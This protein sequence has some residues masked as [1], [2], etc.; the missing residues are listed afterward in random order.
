MKKF[1]SL[2]LAVLMIV[3]LTVSASA[4]SILNREGTGLIKTNNKKFA[5]DDLRDIYELLDLPYGG[6]FIFRGETI[7]TWWYDDCPVC[8]GLSF[9]FVK[10]GDIIW[11]CLEPKCGKDGVISGDDGKDDD[12]YVDDNIFCGENCPSCGTDRTKFDKVVVSG[13]KLY[14]RYYCFYCGKY[15]YTEYEDLDDNDS[16]VYDDIRCWECGK[17]AEF[18][19]FFVSGGKLYARYTCKDGHSTD[20]R[21]YGSINYTE[22]EYNVRVICTRGGDY[23]ISGGNEAYYGETKTIEF[24][25]L[26]GYVLT[27]VLVNGE[28]VEF[29]SSNKIQITVTKNTVVRAYFEK[30]S[31]LKSYTI[32]AEA[33]GNGRI[34]A[35][36]N[37]EYVTADKVTAKYTDTV[38]YRFIPASKNYYIDSV[39]VDGRY[40][41]KP[42]S[43]TFTKLNAN[44][45][46]EVNF[47]WDNPFCD[48]KD[49]YLDAV[50]YVTEAGI[51]SASKTTG[52]KTYFSGN[53]KVSVQSFA[54][55]LAEMADTSD[56]LDNTDERVL[57]A[58]K[59]DL[60]DEDTDLSATCDVQTACAMVREF[61]E[62][63]ELIND[64]S[65]VD[66]NAKD[67]VKETAIEI[68]M[69]S[70]TT[71]EKNRDLTRYDLAS[72]CYLIAGLEYVD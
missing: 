64:I 65:F 26:R 51:M 17:L 55:A 2:L 13:S 14:N 41:G 60:I 44:H 58:L 45:T 15:F 9:H 23:D 63:L 70:A 36:K 16:H 46:I 24:Y 28:S 21:V 29:D 20:R 6:S 32:L 43:Y 53:V 35:R 72:V 33:N 49:K 47:V 31:D 1:L 4:V 30:A 40:V 12:D 66:L 38:T 11:K 71:Y 68:G 69:V 5:I 18:D 25:P 52:T 22:D 7:Y 54:A 19:F 3:S 61:L 10:D 42:S 67:S 56:K 8:D 62:A 57:W 48:V 39:E 50:E 27:D 37:D 59:Y 34:T